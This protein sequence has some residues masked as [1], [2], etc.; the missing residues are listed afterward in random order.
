M[1][2]FAD[3]PLEGASLDTPLHRVQFDELRYRHRC[4]L[5]LKRDGER[6]V[7]WGCGQTYEYVAPRP[8]R[9]RQPAVRGGWFESGPDMRTGGLVRAP[10][11]KRTVGE[12]GYM[13]AEWE[14]GERERTEREF[15]APWRTAL[16]ALYGEPSAEELEHIRATD[17]VGR[18]AYP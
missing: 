11:R 8:K 18:Q 4:G 14:P 9:W 17:P 10:L 1:P 16:V 6:M 13:N 2:Q 7:C 5:Y 3:L 12:S 15:Y